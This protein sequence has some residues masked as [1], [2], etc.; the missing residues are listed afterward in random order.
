MRMLF[1]PLL[2]AALAACD[3][4]P[5]GSESGS[6]G[7]RPVYFE[8]GEYLS[9]SWSPQGLLAVHH[10][11][12]DSMGN[13]RG[14]LTGIYTLHLDGTGLTKV[15]TQA[16]LGDRIFYPS[17]SPDGQWIAFTTEYVLYK[18]RPDGSD[19][20][21][22]THSDARDKWRF[23]WSPDGRQ[24]AYGTSMTTDRKQRGLHIVNSDGIGSEKKLHVP[25]E[26][27][28]CFKC[29]NALGYDRIWSVSFFDWMHGGH[30]ISYGAFEN[31][32]GSIH[33]VAYDTST[34]RVRIIRSFKHPIDNIA[35]SPDGRYIA[36]FSY[37]EGL[38]IV[39]TD[40]AQLRWLDEHGYWP[41]WAPDSH[42]VLYRRLGYKDY[43][44]HR[45]PGYG[46][47]W[48]IGIDG[49]A[50]RQVTWSRHSLA[51]KPVPIPDL[52]ASPDMA[53]AHGAP[54]HARSLP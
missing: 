25:I 44:H 12:L 54:V 18:I 21:R 41:Q 20:T 3:A 42:T 45:D 26:G 13:Y 9:G 11:P 37:S 29:P 49:Q 6:C 28:E 14:D 10:Q 8:T 52:C 36:F 32:S 33:L 43:E 40:G 48:A 38:G 53:L 31:L 35:V 27:E 17:W 22:L 7:I 34:A 2:A 5:S 15:I 51:G 4:D 19:L 16:E 30:E 50:K 46:E 23:A 39:R 47:L 1:L 24:L